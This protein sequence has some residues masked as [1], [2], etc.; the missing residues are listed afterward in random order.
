MLADEGSGVFCNNMSRF[1]T[2]SVFGRRGRGSHWGV[3]KTAQLTANA[4]A[5]MD[6]IRH[7]ALREKGGSSCLN[8][9]RQVNGGCGSSLPSDRRVDDRT[10]FFSIFTPNRTSVGREKGLS[11]RQVLGMDIRRGVAA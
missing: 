5:Y 2:R 8:V 7:G 1:G 9:E 3:W 11:V 10:L 4:I 6:P